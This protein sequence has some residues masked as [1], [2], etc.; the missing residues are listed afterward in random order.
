MKP[1]NVVANVD[2]VDV[3]FD[4]DKPTGRFIV[5]DYKKSSV[6]DIKNILCGE[7]FQL[8]IYYYCVLNFLTKEF[9]IS[10]PECVG[11]IYYSIEDKKRDGLIVE[12]YKKAIN[13][14]KKDT[15]S[16]ENFKYILDFIKDQAIIII[17]KITKK[18]FKMPIACPE[19]AYEFKCGYKGICRY[20]N[21]KDA[22]ME[23]SK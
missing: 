13:S 10:N 19:N 11:L 1:F 23:V 3:E 15:V 18:E 20:E 5:Y 12:E 8:G 7:D 21:F 14:R 22:M 2:R 6:P 16:K 17:E 9:G 4:K